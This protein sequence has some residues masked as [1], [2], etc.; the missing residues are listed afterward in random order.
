MDSGDQPKP[1]K[2][3]PLTDLI[4]TEKAY[5]EQLTGII[6]KVAAAWSR[7]N[8]PPPELD[9]MFRCIESIYKAN[10]SMHTRLKEIGSNPS[11]PKA[12]GDLL[13]RWIDDLDA[14]YTNYTNKYTCG[15]D[16]WDPVRNNTRLPTV[17]A[18]FSN[19]HPP[20]SGDIWTLDALFLLPKGRLK[21]YRRLY[22]RLLKSTAPGRSDHKLLVAALDKLD[23]LL[24]TLDTRDAYKVGQPAPSSPP[25]P[26]P[27]RDEDVVIDL[28]TQSVIA[29]A[30]RPEGGWNEEGQPGSESSSARGSNTFSR[31]TGATSISRASGQSMTMPIA[32]LERRLS[33]GRCLDLFTMQPKGVRL[34]MNPPHLT[35]TRELRLSMDV[36]IRFTPRSTGEEVIHH[37]GHIFLLSDLFLCCERMTPEE[38]SEFDGADMWLCYPP[39]AGKVL[40]VS[41]IPGQD[42]ALQI[43]IMRKEHFTIECDSPST[44][45]VL[46]TELKDCIEFAA[47]LPPPSKVPPPPVPPINPAV[48]GQGLPSGP[49]PQ[50]NPSVTSSQGTFTSPSSDY[51]GLP[52]IPPPPPQYQNG[53]DDLARNMGNMR[54]SEERSFAASPPQARQFTSPP[55]VSFKPGEIIPM[56][57][58]PSLTGPHGGPSYQQP[59]FPPQRQMSQ[60]GYGPPRPPSE[61]SYGP[62]S[63]ASGLHKAPSSRSL[64]AGFDQYQAMPQSAPPMPGPQ[65]GFPQGVSPQHT[66]QSWSSN[67][68]APPPP[69]HNGY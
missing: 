36:L 38:Q 58:N 49:G 59:P 14:P 20:P 39:L 2:A 40:R 53:P 68:H 44:R 42:N 29:A 15:F 9:S 64:R 30:H 60:G 12:L 28:R 48:M 10:R 69:P 4:D 56:N 51:H 46:M 61:P 52:P 5:V 32:D 13:M 27:D 41:D 31:E 24:Q 63:G 6:R 57:R 18:T 11:S 47:S 8:L 55:P 22:G 3:N 1:K 35:F 21:Y 66:G 23:G 67:G 37:R 7:S 45:D 34:Q 43:A 62:D 25:P 50:R 33:A 65:S 16:D 17:L 19:S 26:P 54:I